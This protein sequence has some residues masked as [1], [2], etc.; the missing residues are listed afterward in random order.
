MRGRKRREKSTEEI[1]KMFT[2]DLGEDSEIV[3]EIIAQSERV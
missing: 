1:Q 2:H 3:E